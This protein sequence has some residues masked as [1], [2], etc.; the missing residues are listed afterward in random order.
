MLK[1]PLSSGDYGK[2]SP[3]VHLDIELRGGNPFPGLRPFS[4]DECHLFFGREGQADEILVKLAENRFVTVMGYSGSGKSSLMYCG[5]IPVLYGGFMTQTGPNWT[6]IIVRP[7]SAPMDNLTEAI[8]EHLVT[9]GRIQEEDKII[10]KPI[11][12][13]V[14][15]SGP[16]GLIEVSRY[17]QNQNGEN[18]FFL[19]DQFEE[20]FRFRE[21]VGTEEAL[22]EAQLYV[23]LVLTAVA[24]TKIPVYVALTMRSDFIGNCSVFPALTELINHSNYLV[25]QMTREQ[26]KMIIEGPTAVGGGKISQR[27]VKRL[28]TDVGND[29]DQ[30]PIL[31]HA[32]MR[33]WDYWVANREPGEPIDI[34]HYNA[35][36]RI[37]EALSQHANEAYDELNTKQKEIA[38]ILFKNITEKNQ[39]NKGMRR[40]ARLGLVTEL[41]EA[42]EEDVVFVINHFRK[43]G[44]SLLM[45]AANVPLNNDS[46]IELSH[47]SLMRIWKRLN[48]WV[49]EEFESA[50]MYKRL[51]EAAAMYQIGKTGLWRPPDLQLA[52]NWQKKQ[53][54]T[55]EW[56]QRYD[57]TFER[58]IVFLDTSRI[59]Y[60]A[61]LKNQE[62]MQRRVLRRT[63]A[64]AVILGAAFVVAIVFFV[65]AY[66]QKIAADSQ[67]IIADAQRLEAEKQTELAESSRVEAEK[68]KN[69][70]MQREADRA[71]A[72]NQVEEAL[73]QLR[74]ALREASIA[75]K[76]AEDNL[77]EAN[78][79]RDTAQVQ[80]G[81]AQ[82]QYSRAEQN[83]A[84][85][86]QLYVLAIAQNLST[87]SVQETDDEILAGLL[88]MQGYNFHKR[89][90]GKSYD[91]YIYE[92]LYSALTKL[93]NLTYN[94]IK[95]QGPPHVHIKSVA[96]S[97]SNSTF[98]TSGA[99][100]RIL[101]GDYKALKATPTGFSTPHL[102]KAI[103]LSKDERYLVNG[104]DS[105]YVQVYDLNGTG[106]RPSLTVRGFQGATNDLE[107]MPDGSGFIVSSAGNTLSLVN[108]KTG[109]VRSLASLP[110]EI[111]SFNISADGKKLA[112]AT[113]SGQV[114]MLDLQTSA[115]EVLQEDSTLR[116]LSVKFSPDGKFLA[117]GVD[118][119]TN[120][121]GLVRTYDLA[122]GEVRQ[123]TGH[124]AGV[125]DIEFSPDGKLLASAGADRRLLL[126]LLDRP[127]DLPIIM[128]NNSGFIWDIA[129]SPGSQYLIATC[130]ESEIRV[131]PTDPALLAEQ[132][133]PMLKRN[134]T[135]E[136]WKKYVGDADIKYEYTCINPLINDH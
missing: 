82:F 25:P 136:E 47:E 67:R 56:A 68:Q 108:H 14:L 89:N 17:L 121:R 49:D 15:R 35:V 48:T 9:T 81:K 22:N 2:R 63:R 12:G 88:A 54:P 75:K 104:S 71:K 51:S 60:E 28:L 62:M 3:E 11:I 86:N 87:K 76:Q 134:M 103:A 37:H 69:L 34:R 111:K 65:L 118:D 23:N 83:L 116:I 16:Q 101:K 112:G 21:N 99:D 107:F 123:F 50:Q 74:V 18:V 100:G 96:V 31:Q 8:V 27:L 122:T 125:N 20:I 79:Q 64:T 128:D 1:Q 61:E 44:R 59:T 102:G 97:A 7:G 13:S 120:K 127:E 95:V 117:Y 113:W 33:T 94:A 85:A 57:E 106:T 58:A 72:L 52:L 130:S 73:G 115:F 126:W 24:Q 6:A 135:Q 77:I 84:K 29:Q 38:E 53:R 55:R 129:F 46:M 132:I 32:L 5:L 110:F 91:P 40:P 4:L 26:K 30:L 92:G 43:P 93:R 42:E 80:R 41:A 66:I 39:D 109:A 114:I 78:I 119:V 105:S 10:H 45:P 98:Y 124:R 90:N 70:A 133:C 131:W 36:G 19:V